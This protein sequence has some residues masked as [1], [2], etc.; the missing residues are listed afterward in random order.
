[1][2]S[3]FVFLCCFLFITVNAQQLTVKG[4]VTD[5]STNQPLSFAN[6]RVLNSNLG[7][8]ANVVGE[9]ELKITQRDL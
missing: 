2:K 3:S 8:A 6:I 4:N 1:M 5:R 9:Y 7:S